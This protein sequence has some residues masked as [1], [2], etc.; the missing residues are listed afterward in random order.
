MLLYDAGAALGTTPA[1]RNPAP[2]GSDS[3]GSTDDTDDTDDA[4]GT[5]GTSGTDQQES[6][7]WMAVIHTIYF[8]DPRWRVQISPTATRRTCP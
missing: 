5:D 2:D 1:K 6:A 4:D 8:P 7:G 3:T